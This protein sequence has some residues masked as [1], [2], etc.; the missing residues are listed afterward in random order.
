[1]LF[2]DERP[3]RFG[4]KAIQIWQDC[5]DQR[6]GGHLPIAAGQLR[7]IYPEIRTR[8]VIRIPVALAFALVGANR[9]LPATSITALASVRR[10]RCPLA[11]RRTG[12]APSVSQTDTI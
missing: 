9:C 6:H 2:E 1:M 10:Y 12:H 11:A 5:L 3:Q 4:I 7:S 8:W